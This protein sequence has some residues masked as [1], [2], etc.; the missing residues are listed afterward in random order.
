MSRATGPETHGAHR[1][2]GAT[3]PLRA[4]RGVL[5]PRPSRADLHRLVELD[6]ATF[7]ALAA[8]QLDDGPFDDVR[9]RPVPRITCAARIKQA[10]IAFDKHYLAA[11]SRSETRALRVLT[12]ADMPRAARDIALRS[13]YWGI[14][15]LQPAIQR[16]AGR[17]MRTGSAGAVSFAVTRDTS[18]RGGSSGEW[19]IQRCIFQVGI[20]GRGPRAASAS[21]AS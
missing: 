2:R 5:H 20:C 10:I 11:L 6:I 14:D 8:N 1:V 3:V 18:P 4:W 15:E 16:G 17:W 12:F 7:S 19:N 13:A 9:G 21:P